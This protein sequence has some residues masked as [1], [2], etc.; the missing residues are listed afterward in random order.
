MIHKNNDDAL[1][2][3]A[4]LSE[5]WA[6]NDLLRIKNMFPHAW[7]NERETQ[8]QDEVRHANLLLTIMRSKDVPVIKDLNYSM[9]SRL[10]K[11]L[12]DL[13]KTATLSEAAIV[14][15]MTERRAVWIYK[16]YRRVGIDKDY[17]NVALGICNDEEAHFNINQD[18]MNP[19][20]LNGALADA[21][22]KIDK[23]LFNEYLPSKFGR[24]VF[25]SNDFWSYYYEGANV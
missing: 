15:E 14:H 22:F 7:S 21:V 23:F 16:T 20:D 3:S 17:K 25:S 9:Q 6:V 5:L 8:L 4:Y 1:I 19:S 13:G 11:P 2:N 18:Q 24:I 10:Y 12:I